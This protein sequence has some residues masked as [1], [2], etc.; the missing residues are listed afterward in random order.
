MVPK[1]HIDFL[2]T[3]GLNFARGSSPVRWGDDGKFLSPETASEAG[4]MLWVE[5]R[6]SVNY[7]YGEN[8]P[9]PEYRYERF[10]GKIDPVQVL[11]ALDCLEYQSC[12]HP[13]WE[14]S[15]AKRFCES[16]RRLAIGHLPGYEKAMWRIPEGQ[17]A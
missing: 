10:R 13:G 5:N 6:A 8:E 15:A 9:N 1:R 17:F 14:T 3:A 12:E 11:K 4:S 16:L 2:V 7:R